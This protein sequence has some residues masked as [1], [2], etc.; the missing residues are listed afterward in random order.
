MSIRKYT[1]LHIHK[2]GYLHSSIPYYLISHHSLFLYLISFFTHPSC[3]ATVMK[4]SPMFVET[5]RKNITEQFT[6]RY[7]VRTS[8]ILFL[9]VVSYRTVVICKLDSIQFS[10]IHRHKTIHQYTDI[11]MRA[12]IH[13][14]TY[15]RVHTYAHTDKAMYCTYTYQF[16]HCFFVS[17][18]LISHHF[19]CVL[20]ALANASLLF[21]FCSDPSL[22]R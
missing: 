6:V 7:H 9:Y 10:N 3:R 17:H 5:T 19:V 16:M 21:V 14:H 2:Y 20:I 18:L 13:T 8:E 1:R 4:D 11:H 22:S 12:H 15:I